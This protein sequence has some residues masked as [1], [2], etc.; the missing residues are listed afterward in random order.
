MTTPG[1]DHLRHA[2]D[3][4][5]SEV[6]Q[7]DLRDRVHAT[8]RRLAMRRASAAAACGVVLVGATVFTTARVLASGEGE[9]PLPGVAV[10]ATSCAVAEPA[11]PWRDPGGWATTSPQP[12][13]D[14]LFYLARDSDP[15]TGVLRLVSWRPDMA[16][17][18]A[19]CELPAEAARNANVS[20][21]GRW[22]TWVAS[23]GGALHIADL[24]GRHSDRILRQGVDGERL[25]PVWS[26]DARQ[27]MVRDIA[28]GPDRA[29]VGVI[30][31][32]NGRFTRLRHNLPDARHLVWA[33]DGKAI[34]FVAPDRG[35][36]VAESDG[37]RQRTVR[38]LDRVTK[39]REVVGL[40]S[41][42]GPAKGDGARWLAVTV[43]DRAAPRS[44]VSNAMVNT[45]GREIGAVGGVGERV[46]FQAFFRHVPGQG[47][48]SH[49]LRRVEGVRQI[50]LI[51]SNGE[52]WGGGQE[53][54]ALA[55]FLLLGR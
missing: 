34:A 35:V 8:A 49:L 30:D 31:V 26:P 15:G 40:Q 44:L 37:S 5:A 4:L 48:F 53:P 25:A 10:D 16:A 22:V 42:S 36:V 20:P 52:Y 3:T 51:G 38:N 45:E 43:G 18:A 23:A 17:P 19:R 14:E 21:D 27:L 39:G 50:E 11:G 24:T 2:L 13:I 6:E 32:S 33:A 12:S 54:A 47:N 29:V 41:L 28:A 1:F 9:P 46:E 55:G 7:V